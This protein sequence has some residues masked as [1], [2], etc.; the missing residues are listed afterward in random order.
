MES[1]GFAKAERLCSKKAIG[2]LFD[3]SAKAFTAFPLRAVFRLAD[4]DAGV[5]VSVLV[6]VSKK[7]FKRAVK[8]NRVKRQI[9]EAYRKNKH[10]LAAFLAGRGE[11]LHLAIIYLG[12]ELQDS[13]KIEN[14]VAELLERVRKEVG[15]KAG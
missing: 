5:P 8:R 14:R 4:N 11:A 7:R 10:P 1:N 3:G 15:G 6:S 9:R 13:A 2:A 12:N